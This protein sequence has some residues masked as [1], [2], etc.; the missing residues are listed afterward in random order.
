VTTLSQ[1]AAAWLLALALCAPAG[2][3]FAATPERTATTHAKHKK[4]RKKHRP[5]LTHVDGD[6]IGTRYGPVQ[7][8][9]VFRGRRIVD[10]RALKDPDDL[11][12]SRQIDADALPKLRAKVLA[13]QSAR[14]DGVSG[15]T[16]T[17]A[18]YQQSVQS[19]LDLA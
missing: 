10:V 7:V 3:A 17:S 15:A 13:A 12:R 9:V 19:A 1:R 16:Y 11:E 5:R 8:R 4:K 18:A 6:V 14:I 2:S